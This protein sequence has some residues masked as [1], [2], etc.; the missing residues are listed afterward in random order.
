MMNDSPIQKGQKWKYLIFFVIGIVSFPLGFIL[1]GLFSLL[2]PIGGILQLLLFPLLT[3]SVF[4]AI[5]LYTLQERSLVFSLKAFAIS[6]IA[7]ILIFLIGFFSG[8]ILEGAGFPPF[9]PIYPLLLLLILSAIGLVTFKKQQQVRYSLKAFVASFAVMFFILSLVF[10]SNSF[11]SLLVFFG[12]QQDAST[13][14]SIYLE[15]GTEKITI[16]FPVLLDENKNVLEMYEKPTITGNTTTA[17]IDTEHGKALMISR[18]GLGNHLF[19]WKEV[20]GKDTELF[21]KWL[22]NG[23]WMQPGEKPDIKKTDN[24]RDITVSGRNILTFRLDEE[25]VLEFYNVFDNVT[26]KM[27]GGDLFFAR[28]EN[29]KLNMYAGNNE[30][31]L[32]ETH[33]KLKEDEQTSDDFFKNFTISMSNYVSPE[34]FVNPSQY[35]ESPPRI[36]AWVYS[37]DEIEKARFYFNLDP[38]NRI[39]RRALSIGTDGWVHLKKGWQVVSLSVRIM[40]WD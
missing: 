25:N 24:G 18:S 14:S 40:N 31:N 4:F 39:N 23:G 11:I 13:S 7:S 19:D 38:K 35:P 16:Y 12:P 22:Q 20:P 33:E 36:D 2:L 6:F 32:I 21:V 3:C 28:E 34:S 26:Q 17:V 37:E 30:I 27:E 29:G 5:G 10:W 1:G 15:S 8:F 9:S